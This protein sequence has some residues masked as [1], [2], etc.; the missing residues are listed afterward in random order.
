[1]DE[2]EKIIIKDK[3]LISCDNE[4]CVVYGDMFWCYLGNER[5]CGLYRDWEKKSLNT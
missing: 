5:R 1:M 2:L 3:T 4:K